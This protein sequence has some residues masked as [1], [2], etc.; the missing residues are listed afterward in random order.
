MS[1]QQGNTKLG[2]LFWTWSIPADETCP[3]KTTLCQAKCYA[4]TGFF[5]MPN[6][7]HAH[8]RSYELAQ[9][10]HFVPWASSE[11]KR[12]FARYVRIHVAGD[13]FDA[14]Y[15]RKWL[16]IVKQNPNCRF[17]TYTRSWR[18][19][20]ILQ[21]LREFARQHNVYL[22][23][24]CDRET[25]APPRVAKTRRAYMMCDDGDVAP[26]KVDLVFRDQQSTVMKYDAVGNLVCPY[27]NGVTK[28]TCATCKLCW[29]DQKI[30]KSKQLVER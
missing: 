20:E 29:T 27:D 9:S 24:S 10:E 14:E 18:D 22:W 28:L 25:G 30:P 19:P 15:T 26:F 3:G 8:R 21:V 4:K 1:F 17:Y 11:L 5:R 7:A 16:L 12:I 23:L 13:F 2:L 6:V